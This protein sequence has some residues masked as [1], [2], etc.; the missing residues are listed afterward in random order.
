MV[1]KRFYVCEICGNIIGK[2]FDSGVPVVCCGQK[3]SEMVVHSEDGPF[4]K[5]LPVVEV[6]DNTVRVTIGA[7]IHPAT[8]DH[9]IDWIYL[10]TEKG[11]Q[12]KQLSETETP[13]VEFKIT[14]DKALGV[15]SYCNLH[16]LWYTAVK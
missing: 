16:G 7:V 5:H 4:E 2:I 14:N 9:H 12:R 15:F 3:M 1:N 8:V 6:A 10:Q 11:G 13:I